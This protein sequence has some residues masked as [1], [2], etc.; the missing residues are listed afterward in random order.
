MAD[1]S[2]IGSGQHSTVEDLLDCFND[3]AARGDLNAYFGCFKDLNSRFLGTDVNE[4]WTAAEFLEF[5]RPHFDG[6]PAWIYT[7]I[8]GKRII[9]YMVND[10]WAT[11]DEHLTSESFKATS[12]GSG[13]AIKDSITGYWY[14]VHYYLSFPIP[15][16]L[17]KSFCENIAKYEKTG[18]I[19]K[20]E[21]EAIAATEALLLEM[22]SSSSSSS[23]SNSN[24][25]S[26]NN[27]SD[28]KKKKGKSKK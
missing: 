17:S 20:A 5:A 7:P 8:S 19:K 22:E 9:D 12:R 6:T 10:T 1:F 13:S 15:N 27:S 3:A 18:D 4:N 2:I 26:C 16:D 24:G 28:G 11:F 25:N 21:D 23:N 14:L